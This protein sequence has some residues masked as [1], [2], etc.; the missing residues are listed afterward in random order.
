MHAAAP[1]PP[2]D[3]A[4]MWNASRV[5]A[6]AGDLAVDPRAARDG[7]VVRARARGTPAPSPITK[8]SRS[9]SNGRDACSG[10][11]LR[12]LSAPMRANAATAGAMMRASVPP[13]IT[14]ST[15][16]SR[17]SRVPSPIALALGGARGGDAEHRA[18]PPEVDADEP[19][20]RVRHHHR[21]EER[22]DP[23]RA[24]VA[25]DLELLL[26]RHRARRCRSPTTTAHRGRVGAGIA[27]VGERVDGGR[28]AQL[29]AAVDPTALL[30]PEV[31]R[32]GRSRGSR[33]A[34]RTASARRRRSV[35]SGA[36]AE[37]PAS[38]VA[39][40]AASPAPAGVCSPTPVTTTRGRPRWSRSSVIGSA[41]CRPGH[42]FPASFE[43]TRSTAG[44][45]SRR[46][47]GPPRGSTRRIA[48]RAP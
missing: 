14:T 4:V 27:G 38:I 15:V 20:G 33:S 44:R 46:P 6:V 37:R 36:A 32:P 21:H 26:E 40:L 48:P 23:V 12:L 11:S 3:G 45:R 35:G 28:E 19:G 24:L 41:P 5:H 22:A 1:A 34:N 10:S 7:P 18:V 47:R 39:Q 13:A 25:V 8:P 2:C 29:R 42:A 9:A 30:R 17:I 16:S 31:R 43:S